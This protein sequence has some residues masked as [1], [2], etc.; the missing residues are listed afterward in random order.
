MN[1][2]PEDAGFGALFRNE[3]KSKPSDP[4]LKG[5]CTIKGRK[6]W[7]SAWKKEGQKAG[8]YFSVAFRWAEES[9]DEKPKPKPA[10]AAKAA[11]NDPFDF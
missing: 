4:D 5:D 9:S 6:L 11:V 1:D 10:Q 2:K 7:M 8:T 3:K